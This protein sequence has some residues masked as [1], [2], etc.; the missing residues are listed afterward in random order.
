M[1][2]I[3][4]YRSIILSFVFVSCHGGRE[5]NLYSDLSPYPTNFFNETYKKFKTQRPI[6]GIVAIRQKGKVITGEYPMLAGKD[7]FGSEY[8][9]FVESAGSR[10]MPIPEVRRRLFFFTYTF[11]C[12]VNRF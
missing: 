11:I 4:T 6:I 2:L 3:I 12:K 10:V 1:V 9:K 8:V 5:P 7:Y